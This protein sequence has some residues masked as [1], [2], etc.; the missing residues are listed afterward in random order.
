MASTGH[1][2]EQS[3]HGEPHSFLL[4]KKEEKIL[5][6]PPIAMKAPRGQINLQKNLSINIPINNNK[7]AY[8]VK[9]H[10]LLN[11]IDIAVLN[12][13]TS[14]P[15]FNKL[16]EIK[17]EKNK[18]KRIKYLIFKLRLLNLLEICICLILNN[19]PIKLEIS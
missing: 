2:F 19:L 8:K 16:G 11:F 5:N 15:R 1:F 6:L 3:L 4:F 10:S 7:T 18:P 14:D 13:S 9:Y 12:G 17:H